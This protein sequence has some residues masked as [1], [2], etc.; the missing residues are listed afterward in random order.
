ME[1]NVSVETVSIVSLVSA[2]RVVFFLLAGLGC[3]H[4]S[5]DVGM[6]YLSRLQQARNTLPQCVRQ[7]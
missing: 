3:A 4:V 7:G 6:R 5:G 2:W 1:E